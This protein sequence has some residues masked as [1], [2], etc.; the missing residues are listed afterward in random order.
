MYA[1]TLDNLDKI[2][3]FIETNTLPKLNQEESDNLNRQISLMWSPA[4]S[5]RGVVAEMR[6]IH[7][8]YQ[9]LWRKR[10]GTTTLSMREC[11]RVPWPL[12]QE[13]STPTLA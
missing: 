10:D 5:V 12:F 3:K 9:V 2:G 11:L 1:N 13:E 6:Q 4:S 8:D 7:T